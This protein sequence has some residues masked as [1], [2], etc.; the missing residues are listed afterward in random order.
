MSKEF[1]ISDE[2]EKKDLYVNKTKEEQE[3]IRIMAVKYA[4]EH[5][6]KPAARKFNT[7]P[8]SIRNWRKKYE[9][10]GIESLRIKK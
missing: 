4:I 2:I 7:Y 10:N 8:S 9:R 3:K 1:Y 6:N 5:G